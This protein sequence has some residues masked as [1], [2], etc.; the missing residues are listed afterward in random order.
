MPPAAAGTT[1]GRT[2]RSR[3]A[4][5]TGWLS[6]LSVL[7][8]AAVFALYGVAHH[9]TVEADARERLVRTLDL[10][11]EHGSKVFE[12]Y[13]L[14]GAYVDEMLAGRDEASI[15]ADEAD[16]SDRL[17]RFVAALPQVQD[18]W[19]I[20]RNGRPLLSANVHP[21][22]RTLDLSDRAYFRALRDG[23]TDILV[24][25]VLRGRAQPSATFFQYARRRPPGPDGSFDGIT[26]ISVQPAYFAAFYAHAVEAGLSSASLQRADGMFLARHPPLPVGADPAVLSPSYPLA[27]AAVPERSVVRMTSPFDGVERLIAFHRL[28]DV[29]VYVRVSVETQVVGAAWRQG[30]VLPAVIAAVVGLCLF[31]LSRLAAARLEREASALRALR[32]ETDRRERAEAERRRTDALHRAYFGSSPD[33]LF[34]IGVGPGPCFTFLDGNAAHARAT[35]NRWVRAADRSPGEHGVPPMSARS[36]ANYRRCVETGRSMLVDETLDHGEGPRRFETVLAPVR[37]GAD[38]RIVAIVGAARDVTERAEMEEAL[39]RAQKMEAVAALTAGVAHDF[40]NILMVVMGSLEMLRRG[41]EERREQLIDNVLDAVANG[42]NL[43]GQLLAFTRRDVQDARV[44]DPADLVRRSRDMLAQTLRGGVDLVLDVPSAARP[45]RVDPSQFQVALI[46][47]A[48]NARDAMPAGGTF[49]VQVEDAV[50]RGSDG[51]GTEGV[52]IRVADTG[53]GMPPEVLDR[54]FEPFFTTKAP[55]AGTGL[56]LPQVRNFAKRSGGHVTVASEPGGGTVFTLFL[57]R[58]DRAGPVPARRAEAATVAA[59][60]ARRILLVEDHDAVAAV[61]A[62]L[63]EELGHTV[64]RAGDVAQAEAVLRPD[65]GFDLVVTDLVMPGGRSGLDLARTLRRTRPGMPVLLVTGYSDVVADAVAEGF[66]VLRKPYGREALAEA[67]AGVA[68]TRAPAAASS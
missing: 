66:V 57:P 1:D 22:P 61:A 16:L 52:R 19:V 48:A 32:D 67:I 34:V 53:T 8:P 62:G 46:N 26:A 25:E 65:D 14:L 41:R 50:E 51:D 60:A 13:A 35:G 15:R 68:G 33:I 38:D 43:T 45:V 39:R 63:L 55:G 4:G 64:E 36:E 20:D 30:M 5:V 40:N 47:L 17:V 2:P 44:V 59:G 49:T 24:S 28:P 58:H 3:I 10:L 11:Y 56:G 21:I 37:D 54:A 18:V 9:R 6:L 27:L 31:A 7:L 42:R 29:P 12:T 23:D